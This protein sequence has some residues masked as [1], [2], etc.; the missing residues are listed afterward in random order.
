MLVQNILFKHDPVIVII[1]VSIKDNITMSVSHVY[2]YGRELFKKIHYAVNV[3]LTEA[4]LFAI[5]CV[6]NQSCYITNVYKIIIITDTIH[7]TKKIF[8]SSIYPYELQAVKVAQCLRVFFNRDPSNV[9]KLWKCPNKLS[10]LSHVKVDK[11][12]R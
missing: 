6:I 9:V 10:W 5:K 12:I 11:E 4:K 3:I 2:A 1:N 7:V 8:D